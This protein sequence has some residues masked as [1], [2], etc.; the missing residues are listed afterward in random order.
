[1]PKILLVLL[2]AAAPVWAERNRND[3]RHGNR[4]RRRGG[5]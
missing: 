1:M 3:L 4:R 2:L 5:A